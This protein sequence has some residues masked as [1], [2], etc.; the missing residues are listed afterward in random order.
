M[1]DGVLYV[2]ILPSSKGIQRNV[3]KDLSGQFKTAEKA[4]SGFFSKVGK[5]A[6]RGAFVIGGMVTTVAA[7]AAKGGISRALNIEDATAKLKGLGHSSKSV[8]SIMKNALASVKGTAFGLDAAA[9][10]AASA[11]AAGIK[12]G[13]QLEGYLKLTADAATIAGTSM[14][15]MGS[16]INKVTAKGVVQMDDMNRLTERGVPILQMLAKEYGVSAEEMSAMVSKGK[17]DAA[18]FRKALED[19]VG[20]AALES[21]NT[22]RG[23]FKN[24]MAALSRLGL[25]FVGDGLTGA[26]V[27][28]NEVTTIFD[29]LG[30]RAKPAVDKLKEILGDSLNPK[31]FGERFL[32]RFD[33]M[34]AAFSSGPIPKLLAALAPA[35]PAVYELAKLVG[36]A[37][38]DAFKELGAALAPE[39]PKIA[40]ALAE[41]VIELAPSL[42]D[43]LVALVPLLPSL[44][45]LLVA[46][47]PLATQILTLL[48][49]AL[50]YLVT[51]LTDNATAMS[52]VTALFSGD[53]GVEG[54]AASLEGVSGP[55]KS[56][57]GW[58]SDLGFQMGVFVAK[59]KAFAADVGAALGAGLFWVQNLFRTTGQAIRQ[60]V[61]GTLTVILGLVTGRLDV[62]KNG[63]R[64]ALGAI[65]NWWESNFGQLGTIVSRAWSR[66][67]SAISNG[68]VVAVAWAKSLPGRIISAL[69]N[70][71]TVLLGVGRD[72]VSGLVVGIVNSWQSVLSTLGGLV[73]GAVNWVRK[74]LGIASP[75]RVF[76]K[77]G[78]FLTQGFAKGISGSASQ[79][80][81]ATSRL[82]QMVK[83][84]FVVLNDQIIK[85]RK[86]ITSL[87]DRISASKSDDVKNRL[88]K[89]LLAEKKSLRELEKLRGDGSSKLIARIKRDSKRLVDNSKQIE[90]LQSQLD[91]IKDYSASVVSSVVDQGSVAGRNSS[92]SMIS[93]LQKRL[94]NTI[95]FQSALKD[96]VKQGLDK[97]SADQLTQQFMQ[98]GSLKSIQALVAGGAEAV[99]QIASLQGKLAKAGSSLGDFAGANF[100]RTGKQVANGLVDGLE[101]QI[102]RLEKAGTRIGDALVRAV[103]KRLDIHSPSRVFRDQV[104][105]MVG[106][107]VAEGVD[108]SKARVERAMKDL[109]PVPDVARFTLPGYATEAGASL[110]AQPII[111]SLDGLVLEPDLDGRPLRMLVRDELGSALVAGSSRRMRARL[112]G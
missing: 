33:E 2:E 93:N 90:K 64:E 15:E 4:G 81:D 108:R 59:A 56:V 80:K 57:I 31:G 10:T 82:V 16:I 61:D 23:A 3:E 87:E 29:G 111:I 12:P 58:V 53:T 36:G 98:D 105:L 104:G 18:R 35:L 20:G 42:S 78:S 52:A 5:W 86:R 112:G 72:L 83:E 37:L 21:G 47:A 84:Q 62:V 11:V 46:I 66:V 96:L 24:M 49:P 70:A 51:L 40:S 79:V 97:T 69:T 74:K 54:F 68:V 41:A 13:R 17:V 50:Q 1:S 110:D 19:N 75:S 73:D 65:R 107:G 39:L 25:V 34:V 32:K 43:L 60:I 106:A 102:A 22:T 95:A 63:I 28:F 85:S 94:A 91:K 26:K 14:E 38:G 55:L 101:S 67:T 6:K 100:Y 92:T 27:F 71:S 77:I 8:E 48:I 103:K 44:A 76:K 7:L 9:T 30:E 109:V 99:K 45:D 88:R 89:D